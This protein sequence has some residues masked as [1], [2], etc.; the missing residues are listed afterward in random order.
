MNDPWHP[1]LVH[2]PVAFFLLEAFLI[3]LWSR[4]RD[5]AYERFAWLVFRLAM[6][7]LPVV[8]AAGWIDAG[9]LNP[10]VVRHFS[11]AVSLLVWNGFRLLWRLRSGPAMWASPHRRWAYALL[12][13]SV[14]LTALTGHLG[15]DIVYDKL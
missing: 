8:M 6:G 14:V 3:V 7:L 9:G 11:A 5:P 1:S 2:F 10:R 15:G 13:G 4:K 12:A